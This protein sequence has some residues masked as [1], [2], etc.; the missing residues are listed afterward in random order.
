MLNI[1]NRKCLEMPRPHLHIR[2]GQKK[3]KEEEE[4]NELSHQVLFSH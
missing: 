2:F 4:E 3:K 1:V